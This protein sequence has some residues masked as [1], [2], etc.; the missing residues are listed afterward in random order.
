[1][2]LNFISLSLGSVLIQS[3]ATEKAPLIVELFTSQSCPHSPMGDATLAK[4]APNSDIIALSYPVSMWDFRGWKDTLATP[5]TDLRYEFYRSKLSD[6]K[7]QTPQMV[8][9]GRDSFTGDNYQVVQSALAMAKPTARSL[10]VRPEA[11]TLQI[12]MPINQIGENVDLLIVTYQRG[13]S[14]VSIKGGRNNGLTLPYTNSVSK[15]ER[16][17]ISNS[18]LS[19]PKPTLKASEACVLLAQSQT[20]GA[21]L[22]AA[23]CPA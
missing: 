7:R 20:S 9:Q 2:F 15:I 11:T 5:A 18:E 19:I 1:M 22:A 17:T 16:L 10:T 3:H 14:E 21:I 13:I 23:R 6:F 4:I 8:V 12:S